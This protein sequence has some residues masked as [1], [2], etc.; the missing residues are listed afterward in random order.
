MRLTKL[1]Y[2]AITTLLFLLLPA[3][4]PTMKLSVQ[5]ENLLNDKL[6]DVALSYLK[7]KYNLIS[8]GDTPKEGLIAEFDGMFGRFRT[9]EEQIKALS[10]KR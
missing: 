10:E 5:S 7:N 9:A 4:T 1:R 8:T 6:R 2:L 3:L